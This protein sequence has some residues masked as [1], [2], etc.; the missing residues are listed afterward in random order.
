MATPDNLPLVSEERADEDE[1]DVS[2]TSTNDGA[3]NDEEKE[4]VV[5]DILAERQNPLSPTEMQYLIKWEG[6]PLDQCTWEPEDNLGDGLLPRW[7]EI[8]K[9]VADATRS[10]FDLEVYHAA[11]RAKAERHIRRNAKR[12]RLGLDPTWPYPPASPAANISPSIEDSTDGPIED[13][14]LPNSAEDEVHEMSE[15]EPRRSTSG[16]QE[17]Q[18]GGKQKTFRGFSSEKPRPEPAPNRPAMTKRPSQ[19]GIAMPS[20]KSASPVAGSSKPSPSISSRPKGGTMTGYQGTARRPSMDR[21]ASKSSVSKGG[22]HKSAAG[23]SKSSSGRTVAPPTKSTSLANKFAGKKMTATRTRPQPAAATIPATNIFTGGKQRKKRASLADAMADPSKA[24]KTFSNMRKM[25]QARKKAIEK[26]DAAPQDFSSI[27]TSFLLSTDGSKN[28]PKVPLSLAADNT[29]TQ[30]KGNPSPASPGVQSPVAMSPTDTSIAAPKP[31]AKKS[32]RFTT[33]VDYSPAVFDENDLYDEPMDI[34]GPQEELSSD[35]RPPTPPKTDSSKPSKKLSL[36][37][38]QGRPQTQA[39]GKIAILGPEG[40]DEIRILF[41]GVPRHNGTW[42]SAFTAQDKLHFDRTCASYDL[43]SQQ[44]L[45][46]ERICTGELSPATESAAGLLGNAAEWLRRQS[47]GM[48]LVATEYSILLYPSNSDAWGFLDNDAQN[49]AGETSLRH[50]IYKSP[51]DPKVYPP[52]SVPSLDIDLGN[53]MQRTQMSLEYLTGLKFESFLP[54]NPKDVHNQVYMLVFP[55]GEEQ[56]HMLVMLWLRSWQENCRIF[57]TLVG[58][59]SWRKFHQC[60]RVSGAGTLIFH[61]SATC[62][63]RKIPRIADMLHSKS[64]NYTFWDLT[65]G[66]FDP[67]TFPSESSAVIAP[68]SLQMTR[69]FPFGYAIM[70]TPSFVL[71]DPRGLFELLEWFWAFSV[72]PHFL[73]VAC[74]N[75]PD[76]LRLIALE[77]AVEREEVI[78]AYRLGDAQLQATLVGRGLLKE[79]IDAWFRAWEVL[80]NI[81][82]RYGDEDTSDDIRRI[83]W[84]DELIDPNDEQ[85]LVHWFC[86]WSTKKLDSYRKFYVVGSHTEKMERAY[87]RIEIP[88][89]ADGTTNDPN[90][91]M[92]VVDLLSSEGGED[93]DHGGTP[94]NSSASTGSGSNLTL[95]R[96]PAA[97]ATLHFPSALFNNDSSWGIQKWINAFIRSNGPTWAHLHRFPVSWVDVPMADHFGDSLCEYHTYTNWYYQHQEFTRIKNTWVGLFYTI[98]REWN[99][100]APPESYGRHPWI[101]IY[102]PVNPHIH[103]G[104]DVYKDME[105]LIWDVSASRRENELGQSGSLLPMQRRL[106]NF[107]RAHV[108]QR[109]K[110]HSLTRV[111]LGCQTDLTFKPPEENVLDM[112]CRK[113]K[114]MLDNTKK[115]IPPWDTLL[116][117]IGF[118]QLDRYEWSDEG[119]VQAEGLLK[120]VRR[121]SMIAKHPEIDAQKPERLIWHPP[122][123]NDSNSNNNKNGGSRCQNR[124]YEAAKEARK[125]DNACQTMRHQYVSTMQWYEDVESEGRGSSHVCVESW[126]RIERRLPQM[127]KGV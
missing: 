110:G 97:Q 17:P 84:A 23:V 71:S 116:F 43:A 6:F 105:L 90:I 41:M 125:M 18:K 30:T 21:T 108:P 89:Y 91:A 70:I 123:G 26:G 109:F 25:N 114:E 106:A 53:K 3:S 94:G 38:Y 66:E 35:Y 76:Y 22:I 87:R 92:A 68:A 99:P 120:T 33:E 27:P 9:E 57:S 102:R 113:L 2:I 96:A 62:S 28:P 1:D 54:T 82:K 100:K 126:N 39:V 79:D 19:T 74:H 118:R 5:D 31:K 124:L 16:D 69:L 47:L 7:E 50:L 73:L 112:T 49:I 34:D 104:E 122:R 127:T 98:E 86:W 67:P 75:F 121:D 85:S 10:P 52:L 59:G 11:T 81:I 8:K 4:W 93:G 95:R 12:K 80:Q 107:L 32:V 20:S 40:S 103:W 60:V 55:R 64:R 36:A 117:Q 115:W 29:L 78:R 77:K 101:A 48:H 15:A 13:K 46:A 72:K 63:L 45:L 56:L 119:I 111:F 88:V 24:P 44:I 37:N 61:S 51:F 42:L 14:N 83:Y 65:A 58:G